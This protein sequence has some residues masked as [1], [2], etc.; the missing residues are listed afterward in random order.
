MAVPRQ[1]RFD[2][3]VVGAGVIGL[4]C[5]WRIAQSGRSVLVIE[6][7]E[8][9]AGASGVAAGMLAPVT[10]AEF[11]EQD[12]LTLNLEAA[13]AWAAF[14][15]ELTDRC[16]LSTGYEQ[17]GAL[18][19]AVDSDDAADLRRLHGF[20]RSL[21]LDVEWLTGR[22]ARALEPRLSPRVAGGILAAHDHQ[23][24]PRALVRALAR[25][26]ELAGGEILCGHAVD[27]V[28]VSDGRVTGVMAGNMPLR[29]D[30]VV[31]AAGC[32]SGQIEGIPAQ[33][34]PPVRPVKGQILRLAGA[35]ES[36]LSARLVRTPRCYVVTR[37]DGE[38]IVGATQ[39][40]RG[41][42]TRVTA[43]GVRHLLEAAREVL[44][45]T[46]ELELVEA[47]ARLRPG[48]PDNAPLIGRGAVDGLVWATGHHRNGVLLAPVTAA[49]VARILDG[50]EPAASV[51]PWSPGRFA[52]TASLV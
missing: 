4:A 9:G 43:G 7:G 3:A 27:A 42:D 13:G 15:A 30:E 23:V 37:A 48:S 11:G 22:E 6:R 52:A 46:E 19:V 49:A 17:S 38:V 18:I 20:Q 39:E 5:A 21:G 8:P 40:E 16:G 31:V 50:E 34:R 25:A 10:E 35:G 45:D 1:S 2:V 14:A 41:F 44:P 32:W 51:A 36:R 29:C 26:L 24:D 33:A 28:K 47:A 12:L